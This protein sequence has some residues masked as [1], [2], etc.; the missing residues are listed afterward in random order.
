VESPAVVHVPGAPAHCLGLMCWEAHRLA[1]LDLAVLCGA[2][3]VGPWL[4]PHALV[5]AWQAHGCTEAQLGGL[6][7]PALA[8]RIDVG[9]AQQCEPPADAGALRAVALSWF[10]HEGR[11]VAV[12]DAARLFS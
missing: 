8:R 3:S 5:V 4:P 10:T 9:D 7:A 12:V 1:L 2:G 6:A 11:P